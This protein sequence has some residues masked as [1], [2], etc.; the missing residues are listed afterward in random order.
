MRPEAGVA[1]EVGERGVALV[2]LRDE[3]EARLVGDQ[4]SDEMTRSAVAEQRVRKR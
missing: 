3:R 1:V 2:P 4:D